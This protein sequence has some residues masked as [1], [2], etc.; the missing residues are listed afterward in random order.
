MPKKKKPK[1]KE[2]TKRKAVRKPTA[3]AAA[4][5]KKAKKAVYCAGER[6]EARW[7]PAEAGFEPDWRLTG[8]AD[9][10]WYPAT[11]TA[12]A[13]GSSYTL[14]YDDGG[15]A[16][17]VGPAHIRRTKAAA[18]GKKASRAVGGGAKA[19]KR[20]PAPAIGMGLEKL[21]K[22]M[23][24][25]RHLMVLRWLS[26]LELWLLRRVC[27][28][29]RSWATAQLAS[30]PR[31][32]SVGGEHLEGR[33]LR[34]VE[35]LDLS[36]MR[37]DRERVPHL[38]APRQSHS[39]CSFAD[40]RVVLAGAGNGT[41]EEETD[42][43][44]RTAQQWMPRSSSWTPLPDMAEARRG[45]TSVGLPDGRTMVIGG[46]GPLPP[47]EWGEQALKSVEVLAADGS[48]WS[49]LSPMRTR[50]ANAAAA[51]LPCGKVLVAGGHEAYP[52]RH[53][54]AEL[55][56]PATGKWSALPPM[57]DE[58]FRAASCVLPSGRVA[59]FDDG[60]GG[61]AFD[62]ETRTWEKL[63]SMKCC[64]WCELG[65]AAVPG[66]ALVVGS[67]PVHSGDSGNPDEL[68]DEAT[69][70]WFVLPHP[71]D[72]EPETTGWCH[73]PPFKTRLVFVPAAALAPA[74]ATAAAD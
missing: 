41:E 69:G 58:Y 57:S 36:T 1:K 23:A 9:K 35:V 39:L 37:W 40:G 26:V 19:A 61:E 51:L 46:W 10:R 18:E 54:S 56:N 62:L 43:T 25:D 14:A 67:G 29:G 22:I 33:T 47:G 32:V 15:K 49:A 27:R 17:G 8:S 4:A 73:E 7:P 66:G 21:E 28:A 24:E 60:G 44:S 70:R 63:P 42:E 59:V 20:A 38:P 55:W 53:K 65:V 6:V 30:L 2:P 68:Y 48:G 3:A 5:P 13:S 74:P 50:R 45:S 11:V 12:S 71:D 34:T 31:V 64:H 72:F 52:T 16:E